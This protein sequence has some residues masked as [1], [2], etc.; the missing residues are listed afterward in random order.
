MK[1]TVRP[2]PQLRWLYAYIAGRCNLRCRHCWI[3]VAEESRADAAGGF[4]D[5][6]SFTE[7]LDQYFA[8]VGNC[9][10]SPIVE[11]LLPAL[12]TSSLVARNAFVER[13]Y[14]M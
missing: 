8:H 14:V 11:Q 2:L 4:L 5:L 9:T 1:A 6:V 12:P 3:E 10:C 7:R 13:C